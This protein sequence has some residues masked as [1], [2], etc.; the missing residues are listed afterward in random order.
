MFSNVFSKVT[1]EEENA[2]GPRCTILDRVSPLVLTRRD[3]H[4]AG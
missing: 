4:E 1:D 3:Q 2:R